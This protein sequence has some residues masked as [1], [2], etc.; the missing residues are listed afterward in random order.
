M[1]KWHKRTEG[2]Y[3]FCNICNFLTLQ[4]LD[5]ISGDSIIMTGWWTKE[6]W[7]LDDLSNWIQ[8]EGPQRESCCDTSISGGERVRTLVTNSIESGRVLSCRHS[9]VLY[10][11]PQT[12]SCSVKSCRAWCNICFAIVPA[13]NLLVWWRVSAFEIWTWMEQ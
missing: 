5:K 11:P 3:Y 6:I 8:R 9:T 13:V 12:N 10:K 7:L 4:C 1:A 2:V